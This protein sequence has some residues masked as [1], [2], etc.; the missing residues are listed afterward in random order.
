MTTS[1][2]LTTSVRFTLNWVDVQALVAS[3]RGVSWVNEYQIYAKLYRLICEKLAQ[4]VERPT[5]TST[6]L[7]FRAWL[8]IGALRNA[9]QIFQGNRLACSL[10]VLDESV[11]NRVIHQCL[12]SSLTPTQPLQDLAASTPTR[13]CAFGSFLLQ[14][15]SDTGIFIPNLSYLFSTKL[16]SIGGNCNV[17]SAQINSQNLIR[18]FG[19]WWLRLQLNLQVVIAI[20][21][22]Y[23]YCRFW[24]SPSQQMPLIV[25]N[26][27]REFFSSLHHGQSNRPV[28]FSK[29][30]SSTVVGCTGWGKSLNGSVL[31]LGCLAVSANPTNGVDGHLSRQPRIVPCFF[32]N[33]GLHSNLVCQFWVGVV[34]HVLAAASKSTKHRVKFFNLLRRHFE[35]AA[36]REDLRHFQVVKIIWQFSQEFGNF[37]GVE[38]RSVPRYPSPPYSR[39]FLPDGYENPSVEVGAL[40]RRDSRDSVEKMLR[41][42]F[43]A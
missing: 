37:G 25:T 14:R 3:L 36:N 20:F 32:V 10:S 39:S 16:V 41:A 33:Q 1:I 13:S 28:F 24:V 42:T 8:L 27:Q 34:V 9:C 30:E 26:V 21:A 35:F 31:L 40:V 4:L 18:L 22:L 6:S 2:L 7:C 11:A 29:G 15:S 23:Q 5:I 38:P 12:K 43:R 17:C 19:F